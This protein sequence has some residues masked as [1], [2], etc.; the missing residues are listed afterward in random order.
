MFLDGTVLASS[1]A[2]MT[3]LKYKLA[4]IIIL[5]L[6]SFRCEC[7]QSV[8]CECWRTQL[9]CCWY[10][11]ENENLLPFFSRQVSD[12]FLS[13]VMNLDFSSGQ[14][15]DHHARASQGPCGARRGAR[16]HLASG[17]KHQRCARLK[18]QHRGLLWVL[19]LQATFHP[20][21]W[22]NNRFPGGAG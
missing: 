2:P 13:T 7:S 8:H 6:S 1:Q 19:L 11:V 21:Q 5:H 10:T 4:I 18:L 9:L 12:Q 15:F 17:L 3:W 20:W 14:S 22:I 16:C